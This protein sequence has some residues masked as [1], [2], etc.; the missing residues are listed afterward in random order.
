MLVICKWKP[1]TD[2]IITMRN[3]SP[4]PK[5]FCLELMTFFLMSSSNYRMRVLGSIISFS[6][7]KTESS[8]FLHQ[9]YNFHSNYCTQKSDPPIYFM[10]STLHRYTHTHVHTCSYTYTH[11]NH[12]T[13]VW[14]NCK[15]ILSLF[16]QD[17]LLNKNIMAHLVKST[18]LLW[19]LRG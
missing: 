6:L 4:P 1:I 5:Y 11:H 17:L 19:C 7:P 9:N 3:L 10:Y 14:V 2:W 12:R 8:D 15:K 16:T 13:T 18:G